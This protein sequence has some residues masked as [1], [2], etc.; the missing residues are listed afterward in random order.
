MRITK[1]AKRNAAERLLGRTATEATTNF[2]IQTSPPR[3]SRLSG[4]ASSSF[5]LFPLPSG[6]SVHTGSGNGGR[7][8]KRN[9]PSI[10]F[11]IRPSTRHTQ[12]KRS[13]TKKIPK[14]RF[15]LLLL[16]LL[17]RGL[18]GFWF[19]FPPL[20]FGGRQRDDPTNSVART[21]PPPPQT[22]PKE[23]ERQITMGRPGVKK[24]RVTEMPFLLNSAPQFQR[25]RRDSCFC[26]SFFYGTPI[27]GTL[28]YF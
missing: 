19:F 28:R 9:D 3:L 27:K 23:D 1:N 17:S 13:G 10:F 16:L 25:R 22:P 2:N 18:L 11:P 12:K 15:L 21:P 7:R 24:D 5:L 6:T 26:P 20:F 14:I 4:G 8:R